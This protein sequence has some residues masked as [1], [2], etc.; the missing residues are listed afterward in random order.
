MLVLTIAQNVLLYANNSTR[1]D[2]V[3]QLNYQT[4]Y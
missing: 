4:K 3:T 2:L 1:F